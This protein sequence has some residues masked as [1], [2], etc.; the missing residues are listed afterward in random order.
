MK[1]ETDK[2]INHLKKHRYIYIALALLTILNIGVFSDLISDWMRD[3]NYSHG[4]FMIPIAIY[5]FYRQLG[6]TGY[7]HLV[8]WDVYPIYVP[9]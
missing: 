1:I 8:F 5:L 9:T 3:D 4:F 2:I 6:R 7:I